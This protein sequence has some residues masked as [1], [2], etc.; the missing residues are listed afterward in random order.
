[1]S[2]QILLFKII[3]KTR[4][5]YILTRKLSAHR[6]A[7]RWQPWKDHALQTPFW[8]LGNLLPS[9][10]IGIVYYSSEVFSASAGTRLATVSQDLFHLKLSLSIPS[11]ISL[12]A[13]QCMWA[14]HLGCNHSHFCSQPTSSYNFYYHTV[15][16]RV[17]A[18]AHTHAYT[19]YISLWAHAYIYHTCT[20]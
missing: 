9:L 7:V 6:L 19:T 20:R 4:K 14:I 12:K 5:A 1:M 18:Y 3:N 11:N 10:A 15:C 2:H 17:H 13:T 16:R 8:P